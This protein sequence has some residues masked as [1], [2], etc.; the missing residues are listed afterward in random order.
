ML[1]VPLNP[2]LIKVPNR[3]KRGRMIMVQGDVQNIAGK[4]K[5]IH[6]HLMLVLHEDHPEPWC[7]MQDDGDSRY[8]VSR[9][10]ELDDRIVEEMRRVVNVD[11][12][13]RWRE[14]LKRIDEENAKKDQF[15]PETEEFE[16][17]AFEF[18]KALKD[19]GLEPLA[20]VSTPVRKNG[21]P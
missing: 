18:K 12:A 7:V 20:N 17:M 4:L 1:E 10:A 16:R 5:E 2:D 6:P 13:A 19:S 9:Y 8:L 14:T 11:P 15:N 3:S 21:R